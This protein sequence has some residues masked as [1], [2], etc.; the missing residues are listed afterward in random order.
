[1]VTVVPK[2]AFDALNKKVTEDSE[3]RIKFDYE[4]FKKKVMHYTFVK[5][6]L[7]N[8]MI[9]F[10]GTGSGRTAY[11]IPKGGCVGHEDSAV[12]LKVANNV[13]GIAQ[14]KAEV[15]IIEKFGGKEN[16]CFPELFGTDTR[17]NIS[18]MCEIG[19]KAENMDFSNFFEDFD[20]YKEKVFD[21]K[22]KNAFPL[23]IENPSDLFQALRYVKK[24]KRSGNAGKEELALILENLDTI[25]NDIPKYEPLASL[26]DVLFK[27][28]AVYD[29]VLGDF[30]EI[31]NWAFVN[32]NN[33]NVLIP[34]DWGFTLEVADQ[35]YM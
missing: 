26:F 28:D 17:E 4:D 31:S 21:K 6:Y 7:K 27:K 14:N 19:K 9:E 3:K 15:K 35:Y 10:V 29:L 12:C 8:K 13:K 34:I 24:V 1:M 11:M 33:E 23:M 32:R 20:E 22:A 2:K 30:G 16:S 5:D 25:A 18:I